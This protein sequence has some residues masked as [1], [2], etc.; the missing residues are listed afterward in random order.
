MQFKSN[1][2][3]IID[4]RKLDTVVRLGCTDEMLLKLIKTGEVEK[5]GDALLDELLESMMDVKEFSNWGGSRKNSGRKSRFNQDE[6]QLENQDENQDD[7][8]L[9]DIDKDKDKDILNNDII[10]KYKFEGKVI[11]LNARDYR[12][13]E[14]AYPE[15]NLYAEL[16]QRDRYLAGLDEKEQ[17]SWFVSTA[18]YFIRQ[19]DFRRKQHREED[20]IVF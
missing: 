20:N 11:K 1:T 8:Q 3:I 14:K 7:C 12:N 5:T 6:N 13:W 2:K 18:N 9:E 15:L 4:K 19:N 16:L 17:R 10:R